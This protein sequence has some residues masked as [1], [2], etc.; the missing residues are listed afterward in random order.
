MPIDSCCHSRDVLGYNNNLI[1]SKFQ[2]MLHLNGQS[3]EMFYTTG[4]LGIK[5]GKYST[6]YNKPWN[7]SM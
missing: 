4:K 5:R 6:I 7:T 1:F 3:L 2:M